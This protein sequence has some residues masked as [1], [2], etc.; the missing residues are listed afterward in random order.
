[1]FLLDKFR[2]KKIPD[3]VQDALHK[4]VNMK[5]KHRIYHSGPNVRYDKG[6]IYCSYEFNY[7]MLK[8][9]ALLKIGKLAKNA[10]VT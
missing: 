3:L 8:L 7:R 10:K 1:M 9:M 2:F 4:T 5:F 6:V